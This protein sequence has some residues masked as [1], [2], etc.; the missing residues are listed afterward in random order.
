MSEVRACKAWGMLG[1]W[2]GRSCGGCQ[3]SVMTLTLFAVF[4]GVNVLRLGG[5]SDVEAGF[6]SV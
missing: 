5:D 2:E 6:F 1:H 3:Y 4:L